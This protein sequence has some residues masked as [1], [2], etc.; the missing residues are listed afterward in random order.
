MNIYKIYITT[1]LFLLMGTAVALSSEHPDL[2]TGDLL[3]QVSGNSDFSNAIT[4]STGLPD[5]ISF[6]HVGI[7]NVMAKDSIVVIEASPE[8]GVCVTPLSDFLDTASKIDGSPAVVVKR[9]DIS[10]PVNKM[11]ETALGFVGEEY[12]WWYL[13]DN[14]KMYCSELI[15]ESF[16][17]NTGDH[18]FNA[19][20]MNFRDKDGKMP[21]FWVSL[22]DKLGMAVPEGIM[23]TNPNELS[24][25]KKL[26]EIFRFF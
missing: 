17:D 9:L 14:G 13:P 7:V 15:Y 2:K 18:I 6:V 4:V 12:D 11:I 1:L 5:D 21:E 24:R 8:K 3:F 23:G 16:V 20:P 26:K 10:Y 19:Y 25:D 22:Y